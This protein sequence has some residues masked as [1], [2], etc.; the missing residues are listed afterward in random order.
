MAL[1][2]TIRSRAGFDMSYWKITDW[3]IT[4]N[5]GNVDI[6]L[7]PYISSETRIEG[8]DPVN[9]EA[10]KIRA[11]NKIDKVDPTKSIYDYSNYFSPL[12]LE[13]SDLDIY[14]MMYKY[15]KEKVVEFEGAIDI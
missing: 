8:L 11:F 4:M 6:T 14:K 3:R 2:K 7:T 15:I 9:E 1:Q 12:A 13:V 5:T 10:R